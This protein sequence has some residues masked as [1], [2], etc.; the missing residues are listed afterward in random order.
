MTLEEMRKIAQNE[1]VIFY[2]PGCP[3]CVAAENFFKKLVELSIIPNYK[4]YLLG[5]AFNNQDLT[6]LVKEY[7]WQPDGYQEVCTKPQIFVNGEYIGGNREL[8][9]SKWN[10]GEG[11]TGKIRNIDAPKMS[12]P[13][14]F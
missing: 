5:S 9:L 8:H 4:I 13:M 1:N 11:N 14:R 3:F 10:V 2:K 7:G 12:N 6:T